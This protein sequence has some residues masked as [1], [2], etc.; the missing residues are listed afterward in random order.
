MF[1]GSHGPGAAPQIYLV[2]GTKPLQSQVYLY[3]S[4]FCRARGPSPCTRIA[5]RSR[6]SPVLATED[7]LDW[8]PSRD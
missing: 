5:L 6:I 2:K 1:V 3:M 8:G 4:F 7:M